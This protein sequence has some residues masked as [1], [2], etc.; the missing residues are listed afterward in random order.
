MSVWLAQHTG[1]LQIIVMHKEGQVTGKYPRVQPEELI[2]DEQTRDS[3]SALNAPWAERARLQMASLLASGL[4]KIFCFTIGG[5]GFVIAI[6]VV[7]G[8]ISP[9]TSSASNGTASASQE[10][11]KDILSFATTVLP[12]IATPLGVALGFFFKEDSG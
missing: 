5:S 10:A 11:V 3:L 8:L 4:L 1:V 7:I 12:Y 2:A 6:L 9:E